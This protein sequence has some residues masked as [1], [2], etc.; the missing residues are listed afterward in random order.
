MSIIRMKNYPDTL[1]LYK[2]RLKTVALFHATL[3]FGV[4]MLFAQLW[5]LKHR[6]TLTS[7]PLG[8]PIFTWKEAGGLRQ[9]YDKCRKFSDAKCKVG[10]TDHIFI[11]KKGSL[12]IHSL[13]DLK[14][15]GSR[16][17]DRHRCLASDGLIVEAMAGL[18]DRSQIGCDPCVVNDDL[19]VPH[20]CHQ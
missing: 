3:A 5:S 19:Q 15:F 12:I 14:F 10:N 17:S 4:F 2:S 11:P 13:L 16:L 7:P 9:R 6:L 1:Y 8:E 20:Q 18:F